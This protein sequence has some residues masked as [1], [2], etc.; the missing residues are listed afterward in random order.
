[1]SL[2]KWDGSA[3]S[4]IINV[5][6][7]NNVVRFHFSCLRSIFGKYSNKMWLSKMIPFLSDL[8]ASIDYCIL[9][10]KISLKG[11][12]FFWYSIINTT[13]FQNQN[14]FI[15]IILRE[16]REIISLCSRNN[17][18][19]PQNIII[20]NENRATESEEWR[21]R[22][23]KPASTKKGILHKSEMAAYWFD[24]SKNYSKLP[25]YFTRRCESKYGKK[26]LPVFMCEERKKILFHPSRFR[27][28]VLFL[29]ILNE[30]YL[31]ITESVMCC[32]CCTYIH[33]GVP[34]CAKFHDTEYLFSKLWDR[35]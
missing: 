13:D 32:L 6:K 18:N 30:L 11:Y 1:M 29:T 17:N 10:E 20:I 9:Y 27:S 16:N 35:P 19:G 31:P 23:K 4:S 14:Q 2:M 12:S 7:R 25:C 3:L 22:R 28:F 5:N 15:I 34:H 33:R 21:R 8:S 24:Q 26:N